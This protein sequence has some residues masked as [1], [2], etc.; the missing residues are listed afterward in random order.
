MPW[1]SKPHALSIGRAPH[2]RRLERLVAGLRAGRGGAVAVTGEP[3]AGKSALLAR[4]VSHAPGTTAAAGS[5]PPPRVLA[6]SGVADEATLPYAALGDLVRPLLAGLPTLPPPQARAL[7]AALALRDAPAGGPDAYA[8]CMATLTLLTT[9]ARARPLLVVVDDA[10]LIDEPSAAALL[11]AARRVREHPVALVLA[12]REPIPGVPDLP[13]RTDETVLEGLTR[14]E[15]EVVRAVAG[16]L[17]NPQAA[18]ALR[19][20][21]K[22]VETHLTSAYRKLGVSSRTQLVR[23]VVDLSPIRQPREF[24]EAARRPASQAGD[25]RETGDLS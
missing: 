10:D 14:R 22:T 21:R 8:I 25:R 6:T 3:G 1:E 7:G 13:L 15:S 11:F 19:L 20:S 2:L 4:L 9:A 12:A 16:G 24:P 23:Y 18:T 17:S 5:A